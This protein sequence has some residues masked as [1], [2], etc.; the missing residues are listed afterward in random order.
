MTN[1][2]SNLFAVMAI[3]MTTAG[4]ASAD[5]KSLTVQEFVAAKSEW[6]QFARNKT[7]LTLSGRFAGRIARQFRM[8]KIP[9]LIYPT[10]ATALPGDIEAEERITI[11]GTLIKSGTRYTIEATRIA[12]GSNDIVRFERAQR[13][14]KPNQYAESYQLA[15]QFQ[16]I[17]D[18]YGDRI[19]QERI[20]AFRRETFEKQRSAAAKDYLKL[21]S[22]IKT[23]EDLGLSEDLQQV[24]QFQSLIQMS[25]QPLAGRDEILKRVR[26][27]LPG[28]DKTDFTPSKSKLDDF[29]NKPVESYEGL[30]KEERPLFHRLLYRSI[31]LPQLL[32]QLKADSANANDLASQIETE[33]PEETVTIEDLNSR[34]AAFRLAAVP[35]LTRRQLGDL[36]ELLNKLQRPEDFNKALETWL[37]A[38]DKRLN[39]QQLDGLLETADQ[40]LFAFERWKNPQHKT[41]GVQYL[42]RA[43][44]LAS[45]PAPAEAA[46]IETR[47]QQL[48]WVRLR[49]T[50]LTVAAVEAL[51]DNDMDLAM[52]EG[53]VVEGMKVAQV[54]AILG[55]PGRRVRVASKSKVQ[56]IW[57]YGSR[58]A[59][60]VT[61]HLSRRSFDNPSQA[62]VTR[63]S[64]SRR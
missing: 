62:I 39:N 5:S 21:T 42:K 56:E 28:W 3:G 49:D 4:L 26:A 55:Q 23:A 25:K 27:K 57:I 41:T 14:L 58:E 52:K 50:W 16:Q 11:T 13:D 59:S 6:P 8:D 38:Q 54:E 33:L 29:R 18:F 47:L 7:Q 17:A 46:K 30:T 45:G 2:L 61:V 20:N 36:E 19:L 51:P 60:G 48:G 1:L 12:I 44:G 63:V 34:Y 40:Y 9:F 15:T 37:K 31:R 32:G 43:W 22:L 24:I 64:R 53:R 35:R 10:R